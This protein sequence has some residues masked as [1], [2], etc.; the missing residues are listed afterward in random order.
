MTE[1][2]RLKQTRG[3]LRSAL[4][5]AATFLDSDNARQTILPQLRERKDKIAQTW[6][7]FNDIQTMIESLEEENNASQDRSE[8]EETYFDIVSRFDQLIIDHE[9]I[10]APPRG[11]P[12]PANSLRL[13]K[14]ELPTFSGGYEE[15]YAF[16]DTFQSLIHNVPTIP[17]I[18]K[19]HYLRSALR[20]DAATVI[21][22]LEVSAV[23]Y[24]EAWQ[25]LNMTTND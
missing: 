11:P 19:F 17:S 14:I 13:P 20:G 8:F 22:S 21:Q 4:T 5:R 24:Q 25:M 18:Q 16:H 23:N 3:V 12:Q 15:W 7:Q 9:V 10:E 6:D 2:K 1:L